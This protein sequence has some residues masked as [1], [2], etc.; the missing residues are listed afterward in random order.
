ML[1]VLECLS[2]HLTVGISERDLRQEF[3]LCKCHSCFVFIFLVDEKGFRN[4][5]ERYPHTIVFQEYTMARISRPHLGMPNGIL[6]FPSS[7]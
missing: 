4:S 3:A 7:F 5:L 1:S 6:I 2:D